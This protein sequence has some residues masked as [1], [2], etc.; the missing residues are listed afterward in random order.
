MAGDR[1]GASVRFTILVFLLL[2]VAAAIVAAFLLWRS[3]GEP[4]VLTVATG[5]HQSDAYQLMSEIAEVV[6]RR[7]TSIRLRVETSSGA[8]DNVK[9]L[10]EG[11]VDLATIH[12]DT[13]AA[14]SIRM[15]AELF[16]DY[17]QLIARS[18]SG[19]TDVRSLMG[20]RIA[21]PP[22][23][24]D[25]F[26]NFWAL[27]DHYDLALT[28]FVWRAMPLAQAIEEIAKGRVD[29]VFALRSIRDR[30]IVQLIENM[31]LTRQR[32]TFV[33]VGQTQAMT[34]KR[35]FLEPAVI[36]RGAFDGD[37]PLP[38][39]D[40]PTPAIKRLLVA[41]SA[42]SEDAIAE[43]TRIMFEHR[44]DLTL[45]TAIAN[46][47]AQPD[48]RAGLTI[49]LHAGAERF[50]TR[51]EPSFLQENAEPI[52]LLVTLGAM[53][54]SGLL[55]IRTRM[56]AARKNR[57]DRY[58]N[59]LLALIDE[60]EGAGDGDKVAACKAELFQIL[61]RVVIALDTDE[62]TEEGFQS[63]SLLWDSVRRLI[64]DRE[65]RFGASKDG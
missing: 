65:A 47:I 22:F 10:L 61:R 54:L 34:L 7:S 53:L 24:T 13:P 33:P 37:P 41:R 31:E 32:L 38:P 14:T 19:I 39:F 40:T 29:A 58:N 63:F 42:V 60:V 27:A 12:G 15:V 36:V 46:E 44:L 16:E 6:E 59:E 48:M 2:F 30:Q 56:L 25:E 55:A 64:D 18:D 50:F 17:F 35:P 57:A 23:G 45:R 9:R 51:D 21:L 8:S 11:A 5:P 49:P 28:D 43:L 62:V 3:D 1:E 26:R 20:R 52:A 4:T